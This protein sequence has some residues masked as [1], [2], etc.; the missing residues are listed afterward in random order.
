[1]T[2]RHVVSIVVLLALLA[3]GIVTVARGST[4]LESSASDQGDVA[5]YQRIVANL[6]AGQPYYDTVGTALR[7][8][9]YAT[10]EPFNWRTPLLMTTLAWLGSSSRVLLIALALFS[11]AGTIA[12]TGDERLPVKWTAMFVQAGVLA[13]L[14]TPAAVYMSEAWAGAFI[15][16]SVV[17][18]ARDRASVGMPFGVAALFVREL[19]APYC[20]LCTL[21]AAYNRR[22]R[23]VAAWL[24]A[25][26]L[27]AVYY[28]R[29]LLQ[30]WAHRLP[31]DQAHPSSWFALGG[32]A[33]LTGKVHFQFWLL[34]APFWLT[35]VALILIVAGCCSGRTPWHLR[36]TSATYAAFFLVAGRP[37]DTYWGLVAWPAWALACG[38]GARYLADLAS[39][40]FTALGNS[41]VPAAQSAAAP[42]LP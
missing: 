13:T 29:H 40:S 26:A 42:P 32:L 1:M 8:G 20:V 35:G 3:L 34:V 16:L 15:G 4:A 7:D 28:L 12:V 14:A 11:C 37:F 9:H 31:T 17:A 36:L 10:R 27:Y 39:L 2:N 18:Y 41:A 38:F 30:V 24:T 25:A 23:E 33:S 5:M 6:Q 21:T 19:A 22:W